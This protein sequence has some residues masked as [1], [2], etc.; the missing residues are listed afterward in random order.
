MTSAE[1]G[2][3]YQRNARDEDGI[4]IFKKGESEH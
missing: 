2:K 4:R 1:E 3:K